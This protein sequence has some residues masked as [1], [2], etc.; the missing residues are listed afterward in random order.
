MWK[1]YSFCYFRILFVSLYIKM[2]NWFCTRIHSNHSPFSPSIWQYIPVL[3]Y[4][5][6]FTVI[7]YI[8]TEQQRIFLFKYI[9]FWSNRQKNLLHQIPEQ[10]ISLLLYFLFK[11]IIQNI[12]FPRNTSLEQRFYDYFSSLNVLLALNLWQISGLFLNS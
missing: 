4:F 6:V 5:I 10:R 11:N 1:L 8:Q 2:W 12:Y 3:Y 7:L 9:R